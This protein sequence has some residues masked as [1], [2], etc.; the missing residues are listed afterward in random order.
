MLNERLG[1]VARPQFEERE[2]AIAEPVFRQELAMSCNRNL[3]SFPTIG[4]SAVSIGCSVVDVLGFIIA[5]N[6]EYAF[7]TVGQVLDPLI[8]ADDDLIVALEA[9]YACESLAMFLEQV[10]ETTRAAKLLWLPRP[11]ASL[12]VSEAAPK[13]WSLVLDVCHVAPERGLAAARHALW[14]VACEGFAVIDTTV[15][16]ITAQGM[17]VV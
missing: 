4:C 14:A 2:R 7:D 15:G 11:N 9:A 12:A 13:A 10:K 17:N 1:P 3:A 6:V 16:T 8:G 5:F